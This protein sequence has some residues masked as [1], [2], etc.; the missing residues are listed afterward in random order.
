MMSNISLSNFT[1]QPDKILAKPTVTKKCSTAS[2]TPLTEGEGEG[3]PAFRF[4]LS[5]GIIQDTY[6]AIVSSSF[7]SYTHD[8]Q[9]HMDRIWG[10]SEQFRGDG[11]DCRIDQ[12]EEAPPEGSPQWCRNQILESEFVLVVCTESYRRRYEGKEVA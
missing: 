4:P 5:C 3:H 8:S 2:P 11:V 1:G 12:H 7:I 9:A 6:M 10:L